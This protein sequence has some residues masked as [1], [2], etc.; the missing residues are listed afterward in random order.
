MSNIFLCLI[1]GRGLV[2]AQTPQSE[3]VTE[4]TANQTTIA[5]ENLIHFGDLIDVDVIG[6][7]EYDWRGSLT[8][9]GFLS[10]ISYN[11][12]PVFAL[13]RDEQAVAA[14]VARTYDK[15]LRN[16]K[17][18]VKILDRSNRPLSV[19]YGAVKTPQRVRINRPVFLNELIISSGG[20]TEKASGEIQIFRSKHLNCLSEIPAGN[21]SSDT[22]DSRA[23][24]VSAKD[25]GSPIISIKI[26]DLIAG[27]KEANPRILSGD[28][29]T[30][31]EAE[32]IYVIGGVAN[33]G[34]IS[35]RSQ[36]NVSRAVAS[37]GGLT[38]DALPQNVTI[39][40]RENKE[41]KLIEVDLEKIK[42]NQSEDIVLQPSDIVEIA[43]K[44]GGKRKF[45]P[46]IRNVEPV[47]KG[48]TDLPLRIID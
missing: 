8:P 33:P 38:K 9:E 36:I 41:T 37:A 23:R 21:D 40:R 26:T 1:F 19:I 27:K 31:L 22:P 46:I 25:N 10:L 48:T 18:V 12:N 43:Q 14:D 16:P 39:F 3:D 5:E 24:F 45:P 7:V 15:I 32:S 13:C 2:L 17:V 30:V 47:K 6:S 29:I 20:I 34:Q 42:T 35:F 11:E 28:V 4:K 44:G